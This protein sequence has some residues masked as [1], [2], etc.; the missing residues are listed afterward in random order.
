MSEKRYSKTY[1]YI[2][3]LTDISHPISV[4]DIRT[5]ISGFEYENPDI[6][7]ISEKKLSTI[8][9]SDNIHTIYTSSVVAMTVGTEL[10]P[11]RV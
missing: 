9:C 6:P 3:N 5:I 4:S 11:S 7:R 10:S 8:E 1:S 2:Q